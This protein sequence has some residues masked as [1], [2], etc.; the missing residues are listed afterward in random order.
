MTLVAMAIFSDP[1]QMAKKNPKKTL[2]PPGNFNCMITGVTPIIRTGKISSFVRRPI[3]D[4][5]GRYGW[6]INTVPGHSCASDQLR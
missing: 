1:V 6:F 4:K 3:V 5:S 2:K